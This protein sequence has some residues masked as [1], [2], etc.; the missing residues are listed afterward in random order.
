M[1]AAGFL[2]EL[3]EVAVYRFDVEIDGR[4]IEAVEGIAT[5][6]PYVILGRNVLR[7][8]VLRLDGPRAVLTL[9]RGA[10]LPDVGTKAKKRDR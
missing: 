6:R 10:T 5:R 7:R 1:R 4:W 8:F 9:V 3:T 2:G